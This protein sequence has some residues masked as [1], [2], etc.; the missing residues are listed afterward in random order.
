MACPPRPGWPGDG[1][2]IPD[3]VLGHSLHWPERYQALPEDARLRYWLAR[4]RR[5]PAYLAAD[6]A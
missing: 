6:S 5:R 1:F 2:T 3:I 4:V